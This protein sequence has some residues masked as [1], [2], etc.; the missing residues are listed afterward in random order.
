[1]HFKNCHDTFFPPEEWA[2]V[3]C[4]CVSIF[5]FLTWTFGLIWPKD[6]E[7]TISNDFH[8]SDNLV[9]ERRG[10]EGLTW[11]RGRCMYLS[12]IE[13]WLGKVIFGY[14]SLS[15][16]WRLCL[17]RKPSLERQSSG[18]PFFSS[19]SFLCIFSLSFFKECKL[20]ATTL[21]QALSSIDRLCHCGLGHYWN[22]MKPG[23]SQHCTTDLFP[24]IKCSSLKS[25]VP[26]LWM[27]SHC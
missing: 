24:A 10:D 26:F 11:K 8:E 12:S 7:T 2:V 23:M 15:E 16:T 14:F 3:E 19:A 9:K 27:F 5:A 22:F 13:K 1:M 17:I 6:V 4:V 20:W 25:I 21:R 18:K